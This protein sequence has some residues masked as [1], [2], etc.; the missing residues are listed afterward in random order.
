MT[1]IKYT[2]SVQTFE[3]QRSRI[4]APSIGFCKVLKFSSKA[5]LDLLRRDNSQFVSEEERIRESK[6]TQ[7]CL[8]HSGPARQSRGHICVA[9]TVTHRHTN[10]AGTQRD[11]SNTQTHKQ[12]RDT[13][14]HQ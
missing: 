7:V 12:S 3:I 10:R 4:S 9:P 8:T 11:T 1:K 13:E 6:R 2:T 14:G 5:K